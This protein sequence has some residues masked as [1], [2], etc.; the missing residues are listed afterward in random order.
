M[1][2]FHRLLPALLAVA[3]ALPVQAQQQPIDGIVAVVDED[4]ILRS[5]LE[6]AVANIRAQYGD[7]PGVLP[8]EDVLRRQV[9]DRL[10]MLKLQVARATDSGIRVSDAELEQATM[11]VMQQNRMTPDDFRSRLAAEGLSYEEF[12]RSLRDE[13]TVQRLQQQLARSRVQ[14]SDA[15]VNNAIENGA[16]AS[17][18]QVRIAN[19]LVA[20]PD[21]ATPEQVQTAQ[22]KA[23]GIKQLLDSGEMDFAAAAAR[24][25]DGPNAL[26]G[27]DLGW[28]SY[29]EVPPLFSN[30]LREMQPGDVSEPIR[31][32]SGLTL[33]HVAERRQAERQV[34]TQYNAR[35]I[36]IRTTEVVSPEQALQRIQ[37]ARARIE[38]G[39]DFGAVA[40][41][42]S[43]DAST[44]AQGGDMGWFEANAW[45]GAV[46]AQLGTLADNEVSQPFQSDVG[47]HLIQRLGSREQDVTDELRR[48]Q[49][50][51]AIGRRKAEEEY[52]RFL[53]QLRGE[54]YVESRLPR[55]GETNGTGDA[56]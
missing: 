48:N 37:A 21:G 15:E 35:G 22:T 32:P 56:S 13:L 24:Y 51:E 53:R 7:Q 1:T 28:R 9:L 6:R 20:I 36:L 14:V 19:I 44:R 5:E 50:R 17:G 27:G 18:E 42:V 31:G 46:A 11:A 34:A 52:E 41:E 33:L 38:A 45:G 2:H 4:V 12:R 40:R 30:L 25:S 29:D 8:P 55:P 10:V 47:W 3:F 23:D 43:E 49:V 54:A 39:E 16:A 26:E